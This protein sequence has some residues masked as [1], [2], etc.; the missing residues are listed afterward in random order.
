MCAQLYGP[1]WESNERTAQ[2][3]V[4]ARLPPRPG[5][6]ARA[7]PPLPAAVAADPAAGTAPQVLDGAVASVCP[8]AE[9]ITEREVGTLP[10]RA[11]YRA[12]EVPSLFGRDVME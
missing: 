6:A 4:Q 12:Y 11:L 2:A 5:S 10:E 7:L 8:Q 1:A 9:L 3:T